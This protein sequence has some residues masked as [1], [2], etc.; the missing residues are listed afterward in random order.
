LHLITCFQ[1]L[2]PAVAVLSFDQS[3]VIQDTVK[4]CA[5]GCPHILT[6]LNEFFL[7]LCHF[8]LGL[9]EQDLAFCFQVSQPTVSR[10]F[11][12]WINFLFVKFN[13]VTIWPCWQTVD[14]ICQLFSKHCTLQQDV[15]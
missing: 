4:A 7:M 8:K 5:L 2:G 1:F 14:K 3:K 6:P 10:I 13:K 12:T 11:I 15:S 9:P